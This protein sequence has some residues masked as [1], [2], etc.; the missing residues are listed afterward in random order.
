MTKTIFQQYQGY[1]IALLASVFNG[2][3]GI[4]SVEIMST[5]LSPYCVAFYKC[6]VAFIAI[7]SYLMISGQIHAWIGYMKQMWRQ[8]LVAG[9]FG[10]FILF[11]FETT[12]YNLEKVSIVA[13]MLLGASVITTFVLSA[14]LKRKWLG[15]NETIS[16]SLA[17]G[18][19]AMLFGFKL[20]FS[21]NSI[22]IFLAIIAGIGYGTF[23]TISPRLKIG[24]GLAVVNSFML[25]GMLF[26]FAPFAYEG[27][28]FVTD[29]KAVLLLLFLSL[30]PTILGF[31]CTTKALTLIKSES[32]QLIELSEPVF[33]LILSSLLL[34][35]SI[36]F[37]QMGGGFL[38]I[39]SI[40][41]NLALNQ[42][43]VVDSTQT[44]TALAA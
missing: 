43:V 33:A 8:I 20:E 16:C 26:L 37:W 31:M 18:G 28:V 10:L 21:E 40:Y 2:M 7:T 39:S 1:F 9:F 19:L 25:F 23:L 38:L 35:E 34:N 22:G 11:F 5:G 13:F 12:A 30:L 6:F 14:I 42:K 41:V 36:S 15:L 17:I 24:S 27:L 32:V 4:L 44:E 29:M 3:I